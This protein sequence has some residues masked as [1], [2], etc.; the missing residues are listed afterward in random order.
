MRLEG[1]DRQNLSVFS[2][3]FSGGMAGIFNWIVAVPPDTIKSRLQSAKVHI[4]YD[5]IVYVL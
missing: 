2:S 3:L 5:S 1:S 4:V